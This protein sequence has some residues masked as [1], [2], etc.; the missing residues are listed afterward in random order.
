MN[1]QL[2]SKKIVSIAIISL[3]ILSM[4][5][6]SAPL[7]FAV[8]ILNLGGVNDGPP[9]TIVPIS[10][11][12][13]ASGSYMVYFDT[14]NNG[15]WSLSEPY[16][17]V[18]VG[19]SGTLSTT[20]TVP[21]ASPGLYH[22]RADVFPYT[23][24]DIARAPF[25]VTIAGIEP[26]EDILEAIEDKLDLIGNSHGWTSLAEALDDIKN[27]IEAGISVD[28]TPVLN[29]I[30][31]VEGKLWSNEDSLKNETK[32]I[33]D[34]LKS[35]GSFYTFVNNWFN[36]IEGKLWSNDDSLKNETI[37]IQADIG[38][39]P[40]GHFTD[41]DNF[42]DW[43]FGELVTDITN[44]GNTGWTDLASALDNIKDAIGTASP[45]TPTTVMGK[46]EDIKS[47][48]TGWFSDGGTIEVLVDEVESL[49]KDTT[50]GLSALSSDIAD[51]E[52]KLDSSTYGLSAIKG[53]VDDINW[54]DI[55]A[56]KGYVDTM[57]TDLE[58]WMSTN[59]KTN[60]DKIWLLTG[61]S[62]GWANLA[63]ALDDIKNEI[64]GIAPAEAP[65][66]ESRGGHVVSAATGTNVNVKKAETTETATFTVTVRYV[67]GDGGTK[68]HIYI[69]A[70]FDG[71]NWVTL[72]DVQGV[73]TAYKT[74]TISA[75]GVQITYD[76]L[77][78]LHVVVDW[79]ISVTAAS[80]VTVT[81]T[82]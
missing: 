61:S 14:N 50:Y 47:E 49:L 10:G 35:G 57:E 77:D 39:W 73:T 79:G 17:I 19:A 63:A 58:T 4:F 56:I 8:A 7:A 55:T 59:L 43:L 36:D 60:I 69:K 51:I 18:S 62:H 48:L 1:T 20:L 21:S 31:D 71:T 2:K 32:A 22:I 23:S 46:L 9:G 16:K 41:M 68:D 15:G 70:T 33:E 80:G 66:F 81:W 25:A 67:L 78:G 72:E 34:T 82:P 13:F 12:G 40:S 24:P 65:T 27:E 30:A 42:A 6:S 29:A 64:E 54:A 26:A 28:L 52:A 37:A 11:S 3:F 38:T 75:K 76:E 45:S 5:F 53:Y 74:L 44:T